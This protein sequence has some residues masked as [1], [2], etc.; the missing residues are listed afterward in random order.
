MKLP[1]GKSKFHKVVCKGGPW[2]G[3]DVLVPL[4]DSGD[5]FSLPIRVGEYVGRY[6]LNTGVWNGQP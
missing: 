3:K 1:R 4:Q 2:N 6:N 5:P